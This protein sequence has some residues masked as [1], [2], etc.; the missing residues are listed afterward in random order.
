MKR[1]EF[2]LDRLLKVKRQVER[3]AEME[4][5]RCRR[6][7]DAAKAR[8]VE[9]NQQLARLSDELAA[10]VGRPVSPAQWV[11][12]YDYSDRIG[13]MIL[14]AEAD[15]AAAEQAVQA[16]ADERAQVAAEAEGLATLKRQQWER[17]RHEVAAVE[18][19]RAD[20]VGLRRWAADET[21]E[22]A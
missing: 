21:R 14:A 12:G 16:A 11:T 22:A 18:Q 17:W 4:L 15:V 1:F 6:Q 5:V 19:E 13:Q 9:L 8:V 20:E 3:M 7:L 2:S 10:R